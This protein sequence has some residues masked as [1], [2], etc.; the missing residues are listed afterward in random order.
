MRSYLL[1][2]LLL[3]AVA[4]QAQLPPIQQSQYNYTQQ[5]LDHFSPLDN[6]TWTQR[7]WVINQFY[8]PANGPVILYICGK[9]TAPPSPVDRPLG[10]LLSHY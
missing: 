10:G 8:D 3:L 5:L 2:V 7:Y 6:R 1:A 4:C 9:Q